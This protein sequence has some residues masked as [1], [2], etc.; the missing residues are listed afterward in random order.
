MIYGNN[1]LKN[2]TENALNTLKALKR[3]YIPVYQ[4]TAKPFCRDHPKWASD[5]HGIRTLASV[6]PASDEFRKGKGKLILF[7]RKVWHCRCS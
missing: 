2:T 3:S 4:G 5:V 7:C 6:H 1:S